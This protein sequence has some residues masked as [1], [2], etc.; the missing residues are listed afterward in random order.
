[1]SPIVGDAPGVL[2]GLAGAVGYY[3]NSGALDFTLGS[4][5]VAIF[6]ATTTPDPVFTALA[7]AAAPTYNWTTSLGT[8]AGYVRG[9]GTY[10][11]DGRA[12]WLIVIPLG[13]IG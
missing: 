11:T 7:G 6:M 8:T 1:M 4:G 9:N 5:D 12:M 2:V 10:R 3:S 13:A